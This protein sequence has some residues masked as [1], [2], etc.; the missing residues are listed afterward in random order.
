MQPLTE[1]AQYSSQ[2][3]PLAIHI[4]KVLEEK[5]GKRSPHSSCAS[6]SASS[7]SGRSMMSSTAMGTLMVWTS[8]KL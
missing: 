4:G 3:H 8:S 6:L 7:I 1:Q 5:A 2:D